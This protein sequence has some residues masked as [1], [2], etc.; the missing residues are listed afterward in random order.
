[1]KKIESTETLEI[2]R[3][4]HGSPIEERDFVN[5][6]TLL[7]AAKTAYPIPVRVG[8]IVI[9]G[10]AMRVLLWSPAKDYTWGSGVTPGHK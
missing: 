9:I 5:A 10:G 7:P 3:C 1:M 8:E 6:G 2:T 4:E